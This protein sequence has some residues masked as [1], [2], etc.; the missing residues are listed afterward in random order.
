VIITR[1]LIGEIAKPLAVTLGILATLFG[2]YSAAGFLA[3]A[4]NGLLP[5]DSIAI[6]IAL[7]VLIALE[8]LIPISLYIAVVLAFGRLNSDSE[9]TAMF[10]LRVTPARV[11][12]AVVMLAGSLAVLVAGLSLF[13]RP[14]A[15]RT[16]H[17][18]VHRAEGLLNMRAMEAGT[19]Y[20]GEQGDRVIHLT[21]RDN[22]D[23]PARDIFV[24]L[25]RP[26]HVEV[27]YARLAY[28][29]RKSD[30]QGANVY[31]GGAHIYDLARGTG[32]GDRMLAV[33]GIVLNPNNQA[34]DPLQY[35]SAAASTAHL[36]TSRAPEDV[37]ELQWRLSN[38]VSA[39][40]LGMLAVPLSR[41]RPRQSRYARS[42]TAILVYSAYYLLSMT[43]RTW[44][45]HGTVPAVPG[46][47]W[48]PGLLA[49]VL[50]GALVAPDIRLWFARRAH[51]Q[52]Q[53]ANP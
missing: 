36:L 23:A 15:Y 26:D 22:P 20:V 33:D 52:L 17:E 30:E 24:R 1:Y 13:A 21:R 28:Q 47:W 41:A 4:V 16:S 34:L 10:A 37:A 32:R 53:S 50:A 14:W 12:A 35:K 38:P 51:Q 6:L 11:M 27:I 29:I 40:L 44:V 8:V 3:D 48:A 43:A 9:M 45:Q 25:N 2:S 46:L 18:T 7:K 39:L 49:L 5:L 31:L 19:F 42:G